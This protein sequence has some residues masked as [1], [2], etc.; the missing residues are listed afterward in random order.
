MAESPL[1]DPREKGG[2]APHPGFGL[3]VHWPFCLAKCPYCDFNSHV[4]AGIDQGRWRAALLAALRRSSENMEKRPLSSVFFGGGTPSLMDPATVDAVL[5]EAARLY[6]LAEDFEV[7]LEAN[8]TSAEAARF[9]GF[10]AAGVNRVS[11]GVQALEDEALRF[12]GRRHTADEALA[13]LAIGRRIFPRLSFDLI[14]AR[15]RQS[16]QAWAA[17]L[18][19]AFALG[20]AH[21]SLYQLT[22][23]EGTPFGAAHARGLLPALEEERAAGLYELTQGLCAEAGLPA[24]EISNH[25]RPGAECRHNLLYWRYADYL[26]VGPGAH[27]RIDGAATSAVRAPDAWLSA[28][29]QGGDGTEL[30]APLSRHDQATEYL[31]MSLRLAEGTSL[32]RYEALGGALL[33]EARIDHLAEEGLLRHEGGRIAAT[34]RGRLLLNRVIAALAD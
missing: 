2:P 15:P 18:T 32:A 21:L 14:Y 17:E 6:P 22:Y 3:Y 7:T 29:E 26:G 12:L 28:V 30:R 19:R 13:A 11:I 5:G 27:G 20:P 8:P 31:L 9:E 1:P 24:Y 33:A 34:P 10:R 25:A 4:A 16:E 23:E